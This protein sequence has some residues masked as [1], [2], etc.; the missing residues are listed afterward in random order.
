MATECEWCKPEWE[1][2]GTCKR[3]FNG[4]NG[5]ATPPDEVRCIAYEPFG[6]CPQCGR[7]LKEEDNER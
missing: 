6:F 2:C 5:C 1:C 3:F 7:K 4:D